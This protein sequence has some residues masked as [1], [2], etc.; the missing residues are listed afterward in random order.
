MKTLAE[1]SEELHIEVFQET[2]CPHNE[3]VIDYYSKT[4]KIYA[5]AASSNSINKRGTASSTATLVTIIPTT[6]VLYI[7]ILYV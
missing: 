2:H 5:C 1:L 6:I 4:N 7:I 3:T